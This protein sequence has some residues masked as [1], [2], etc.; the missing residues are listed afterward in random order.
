VVGVH[1]LHVWSMTSGMPV[2]SAHV[3]V[4]QGASASRVLDDLCTCLEQH[5]DIEH[6]TIQIERADR[7]T[8]EHAAH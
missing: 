5:F 1:D 2:M 7:S 4:A 3:V 8:R 6:S